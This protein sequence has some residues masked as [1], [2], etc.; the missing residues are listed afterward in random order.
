M[1]NQ[2]ISKQINRCKPSLHQRLACVISAIKSELELAYFECR[3]Q[4]A[5]DL[6]DDLIRA[7][8][9]SMINRSA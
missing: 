8:F 1:N 6:H 7:E 5:D 3:D 2:N 9:L 4:D